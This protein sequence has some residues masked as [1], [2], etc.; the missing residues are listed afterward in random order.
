MA[1]GSQDGVHG[2][3][4][5]FQGIEKSPVKIKEHSLVFHYG[6]LHYAVFDGKATDNTGKRNRR[7]AASA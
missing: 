4:K 6:K 7:A 5:V 1:A 3:R 2:I